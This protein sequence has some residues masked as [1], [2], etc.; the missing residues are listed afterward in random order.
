MEG[1]MEG[2]IDRGFLCQG[3]SQNQRGD[4]DFVP[5]DHPWSARQW[6][7]GES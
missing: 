5:C 7:H 6:D 2:G 4:K 3:S 1:V